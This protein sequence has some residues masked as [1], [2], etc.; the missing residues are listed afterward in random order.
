MAGVVAMAVVATAFTSQAIAIAFDRRWGVLRMLGTT[1]LGPRGLLLGKLGAVLCV[2]V[3]QVVIL[4]G[5][6][7]LLG[8]RPAPSPAAILGGTVFVLLGAVTF[9]SFALVVA[10]TMRREG[11]LAAAGGAF[12]VAG[13]GGGLLLAFDLLPAPAAILGG[14]VFVLLGAVTFVSFALVVAGTMRP[15]GVLAL[16]NVAFVVMVLGAGLLLPLD[17]MPEPVAAVLRFLPPGALGEGLRS[18]S[19]SP[20]VLALAVL[21]AWGGLAVWL[22]SRYFRWD[23]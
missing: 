7:V 6:G 14:T 17:L 10:G 3:V 2:L 16:A 9:V 11:L 12:L 8:W 23:A 4:A 22:A 1:P 15:E 18:L 20:D 5:V 19:E 21:A 13:P